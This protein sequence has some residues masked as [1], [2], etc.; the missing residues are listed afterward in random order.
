MRGHLDRDTSI[1]E[2]LK[3]MIAVPFM[4]G[5]IQVGHGW[6]CQA[7]AF[8]LLTSCVSPVTGPVVAG[9]C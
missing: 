9:R 5:I 4:A 3:A 1:S 6:D 7:R 2:P 8:V